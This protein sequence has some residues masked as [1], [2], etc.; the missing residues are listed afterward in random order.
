MSARCHSLILSPH[1]DDGVLS[2]ALRIVQE[3]KA[4]RKV[5]VA[6]LFTEDGTQNFQR[7]DEDSK[8]LAILDAESI[9]LGLFD[10]PIRDRHYSGFRHIVLEDHRGQEDIL[11][12]ARNAVITLYHELEPDAVFVPLAIGNHIDHWLTYQTWTT[13]PSTVNILFYEDRPYTLLP[14][15]L[16]VRLAQLGAAVRLEKADRRSV[17]SQFLS[18]MHEKTFYRNVITNETEKFLHLLRAARLLHEAPENLRIELKPEI[19]SSNDDLE[20]KQIQAAISEYSSQ[21]PTLY[22][23]GINFVKESTEYAAT[24]VYLSNYAERYWKNSC[25]PFDSQ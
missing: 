1:L 24:L 2:C 13:L 19:I 12:E 3:R 17:L 4:G 11:E 22:G 6:T 7:K 10:A 25:L 23:D 18:G 16:H 14:G 5:V 20:V 21:L 9:W 15:N 8:A